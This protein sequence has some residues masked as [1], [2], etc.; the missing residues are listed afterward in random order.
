MK[1]KKLVTAIAL[2][3]GI[4]MVFCSCSSGAMT[5]ATSE[6]DTNGNGSKTTSQEPVLDIKIDKTTFEIGDTAKIEIT[7]NDGCTGDVKVICSNDSAFEINGETVTA[8]AMGEAKIYLKCDNAESKDIE[9]K[10]VVLADSIT[11][12]KTEIKLRSGDESKL[13]ATVLPAETTNKSITWNSK[14]NSIA[15]VNENGVVTGK[16]VGKTTITATDSTGRVSAECSVEVLPV[17]VEKVT[18]SDSNVELGKG[19]KFIITSSVEPANATYKTLKWSSSD[20]D[21]ADYSDGIIT[22]NG[23]GSAQIT[24]TASNGKSNTVSVTVTKNKNSKTMYTTNVL[25]VRSSPSTNGNIIYQL[26]SDRPVEIVKSGDWSMI[27]FSSGKVGY[28]NSSYLSSVKPCKISGVPYLNQFSLGYPTGCEAVSATMVLNFHGYDVSTSK[29]ISAIPLGESK[30]QVNGKWVGG[31]PFE[32]FVG[33]PSK[34]LS[35]GSYGCFAKPLVQAMQT[36]AGSKVKNIS[37][38]SVDTL[39]EYV[40]NGEPVV[41][42]CVK[43]GNPVK[44]GVTWSYPDGSGKFDE[45]VG[46]HCAVLIG[47]DSNYVYLNDPSAGQNVTQP[48]SAFKSNFKKLYSQ[49]IVVL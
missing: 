32:V 49:A 29:V 36:I 17:E 43:N 9:I 22:A 8:I 28:V 13:S 6:A 20:S 7:K 46:E 19:Q 41:V 16:S 4:L 23:V 33:H 27:N 15:K 1:T 31:N 24:A 47:Y 18:V 44:S 30:H 40:E 14:D 37:G 2:V 45:L 42:W 10:C 5:A 12:D 34:G 25:N 35:T 48:I 21:V 3:F 26:A 11:L 39:F 38:C